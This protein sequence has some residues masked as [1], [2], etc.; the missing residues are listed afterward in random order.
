MP[1]Q[2]TCP[3]CGQVLAVGDEY[4]G[5]QAPCPQCK[6]VVTFAAGGAPP[7]A[8]TSPP[9]PASYPPP[10]A[11]DAGQAPAYAPPGYPQQPPA[12]PR[13]IQELL[14]MIGI[15]AGTFF[16]MLL[17]LSTFLRW[18]PGVEPVPGMSG[19]HFGD[20]RLILLMALVLANAV[21]L[22]FLTR[23]YLP[24]SMVIAGAFGTFAF[25]AMLAHLRAGGAGIYVGFIAAL[26]V[27]GA[28]IWTAVRFP[29]A[30]ELPGQAGQ[31]GFIRIFGALLGS[32]TAA[33]VLGLIYWIAGAIG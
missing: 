16:L 30:L 24:L 6:T 14:T 15:G 31:T 19:T 33:L 20:G 2:A 11:P 23:K 8:P 12:P 3:G 27:M 9:P 17:V 4:A 22:N 29:L 5:A 32:Q 25:M 21:G 18:I 28:C 26:G 13:D 1:I 10:P 7:A